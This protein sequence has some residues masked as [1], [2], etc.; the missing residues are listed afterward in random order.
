MVMISYESIASVRIVWKVIVF[1][2]SHEK[3]RLRIRDE[4]SLHNAH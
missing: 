2:A 3:L 1:V 4:M